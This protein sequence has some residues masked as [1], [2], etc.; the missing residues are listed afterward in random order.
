MLITKLRGAECRKL[1]ARVGFGR[2]ACVSNSRP[3]I[4]PIYFSYDA[5]C[6]DCCSRLGG[7]IEWM[8]ENPLVCV[9]ADQIVAHDYWVR[10]VAL[11]H[12]LE[13]SNSPKAAKGREYA[14]SL[15]ERRALW[16]QSGYSAVQV[17]RHRKPVVPVFIVFRSRGWFGWALRPTKVTGTLTHI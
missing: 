3:Y 17:R 1:L 4:V 15:I 12:Y 11:G 6:L 16:W 8:R 13:F 5:E 2:L 14:R 9:E 7:K 10:V